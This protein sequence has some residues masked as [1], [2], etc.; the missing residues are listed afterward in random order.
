MFGNLAID[1]LKDRHPHV[2]DLYAGWGDAL[3]CPLMCAS[4]REASHDLISF[5][6]QI[7]DRMLNVGKSCSERRDIFLD[8]LGVDKDFVR[9]VQISRIP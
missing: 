7:L 1:D 2:C 6:D 4:G 5:C 9:D 3:P 8:A